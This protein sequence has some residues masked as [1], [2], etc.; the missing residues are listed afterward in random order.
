MII[1][2]T[3]VW[4]RWLL[5]SSGRLPSNL[6]Q[7]L[8]CADELAISTLSIY[9]LIIAVKRNRLRLNLP[10]DEWIQSGL[11]ESGI[12]AI[13]P[14]EAIVSRA[15]F[16]PSNHGDPIDRIIIATASQLSQFG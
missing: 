4:I 15:G 8:D 1:L 3:H 7:T 13:P 14:D 6:R 11:S 9:E 12:Q 5:P 10:L 16:L 2:D